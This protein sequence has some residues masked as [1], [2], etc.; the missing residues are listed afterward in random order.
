MVL[1]PSTSREVQQTKEGPCGADIVLGKTTEYS[2]GV[3]R[4]ML[5]GMQG[6]R[7]AVGL[8]YS[9]PIAIRVFVGLMDSFGPSHAESIQSVVLP[10]GKDRVFI[11]AT[12]PQNPDSMT[13]G[14]K[15]SP[16]GTPRA[17]LE[18][19]RI[20]GQ[21]IYRFGMPAGTPKVLTVD[22]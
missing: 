1:L 22:R 10:P 16:E 19:T 14:F 7:L 21:A 13:F 18:G 11:E 2:V 9:S 17:T 15:V 4:D 6:A 5:T 12:F 8:Y 3:R 20:H